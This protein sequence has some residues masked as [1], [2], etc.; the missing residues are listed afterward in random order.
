M[1]ERR[2]QGC[3]Q[4]RH[5]GSIKAHGHT[6]GT[7]SVAH[8]PQHAAPLLLIVF[9]PAEQSQDHR[10]KNTLR[11]DGSHVDLL[12]V[13]LLPDVSDFS[14][15]HLLVLHLD[16]G[17]AADGVQDVAVAQEVDGAS[18]LWKLCE[19]LPPESAQKQYHGRTIDR[20]VPASHGYCW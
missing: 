18:F 14:R 7:S 20:L 11:S 16:H 10:L 5:P 12:R 15:S 1:A 6:G 3:L 4:F 8:L 17:E 19:G 13:N 9:I 2:K